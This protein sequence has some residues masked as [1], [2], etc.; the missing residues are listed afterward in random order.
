[1]SGEGLGGTNVGLVPLLGEDGLDGAQLLN[2]PHGGGSPV[3]V[4]V[5]DLSLAPV[6]VGVGHGE[7]HAVLP[8][9][10]GRRDHV[11]PVGVGGVPDQLGVDLGPAGLGVLELLEDDHAAAARNDEAVPVLIERPAGLLGGVVVPRRQRAHAVEHGREAP[12][13]GLARPAEGEVGLA[14][15]DLLHPGPDAV[16]PGGARRRDGPGGSLKLEGRGEDGRH[17]R[18]HRSGDAERPDLVLPPGRSSLDGRHGLDD[19]GDGRSALSKYA[20]RPGVL[21]ILLVLQSGVLDRVG[22]GDV[23]ELGV[24]AAESQRSLG[25]EG[26]EILVGQVRAGVDLRSDALLGGL[27]AEGDAGLALLEGGRDV[28]EGVPEAGRDAHAGDH[29]PLEAGDFHREARR[30]SRRPPRPRPSGANFGPRHRGGSLFRR[31]ARPAHEGASRGCRRGEGRGGVHH[32]A[33]RRCCPELHCI[34]RFFV[35]KNVPIRLV[36]PSGR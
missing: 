26:L 33:E 27:L 1:M 36:T 5:L 4:D 23:G 15:L 25:D 12:P 17:G 3:G 34:S 30:G 10:P 31:Q 9:H 29:D 2:V 18:S 8:A 7:L 35:H 19:V 6:L 16:R 13:L 21:L 24:L 32:R 20:R 11:V 28:L 14:Q 22:H